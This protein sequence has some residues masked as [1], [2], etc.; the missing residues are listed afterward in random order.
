MSAALDVVRL[1]AD[2]I[3]LANPAGAPHVLLIRRGKDPY[4]GRWALPGGHVDPGYRGGNE[5]KDAR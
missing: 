1:T 2:V 4:A 3:A 5:G